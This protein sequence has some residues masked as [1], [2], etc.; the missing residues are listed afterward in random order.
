MKRKFISSA[1]IALLLTSTMLTS[2]CGNATTLDRIGAISIQAAAG[3]KAELASLRVGGLLSEA[4]FARLDRQADA[5]NISAKSLADFLNTLPGVTKENKAQIL[6]KVAELVGLVS[7]IATNPDLIGAK[8]DSTA[9][10]ILQVAI[11]T[12]QNAS[13]VVAGLNPPT[14]V[15]SAV[16]TDEP[17]APIALNK[18]KIA[19]PK[20]PKDTEKYFR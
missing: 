3:Y 7:G 14:A 16:A 15:R 1:L 17:K 12:L 8:A 5:L 4:K 13:I 2:A 11:I 10:K 19:T 9:V 6:S 20:L 18:V